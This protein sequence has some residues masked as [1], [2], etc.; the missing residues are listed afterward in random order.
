MSISSSDKA[1]EIQRYNE[2][3]YQ[4]TTSGNFLRP[5]GAMTVPECLRSPYTFFIEQLQ[6]NITEAP[7]EAKVLELGSGT[8]EF[9]Q[10]L[11]ETNKQIVASD[12][13]TESVNYL[14]ARYTKYKN[15]RVE[16]ADI[17]KLPF[18]DNEFDFVVSAG[19]LGFGSWESV[20]KEI[21]RVLK[22]G[23]LYIAVDSLNDNPIYIINRFWRVLSG[24][25]TWSVAKNIPDTGKIEM[26]S[27]KFEK[28]CVR[29]FGSLSWALLL[30]R[31]FVREDYLRK[32][33]DKF[34]ETFSIRKSAF[35]FVLV[36]KK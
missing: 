20:H 28:S 26:L 1:K 24:S 7:N 34:D 35:K 17:E 27:S 22:P 3:G 6:R 30:L 32:V 23:G 16:I 36:G 25:R 19:V 15:L 29:Y 33:S 11:L 14:K 31:R 8:G 2:R 10:V 21:L 4:L 5:T 12:L 18:H 9:T 13:S